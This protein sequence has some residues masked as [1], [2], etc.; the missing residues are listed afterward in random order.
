MR[1]SR[2]WHLGVSFHAT[3]GYTMHFSSPWLVVCP[4]KSQCMSSVSDLSLISVYVSFSPVVKV[5]WSPS[6]CTTGNKLIC[7]SGPNQKKFPLASGSSPESK[8][9]VK[10]SEPVIAVSPKKKRGSRKGVIKGTTPDSEVWDMN[11]NEIIGIA[12]RY[13]GILCI[14][15]RLQLYPFGLGSQLNM[16]ITMSPLCG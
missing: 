11:D 6:K 14:L 12:F 4:P 10:P 2:T 5:C 8:P 9:S 7:G 3:T 13:L 15:T 1:F 16:I